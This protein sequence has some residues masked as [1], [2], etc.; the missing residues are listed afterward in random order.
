VGAGGGVR[1]YERRALFIALLLGPVVIVPAL[2]TLSFALP[3]LPLP[4]NR[5][6]GVYA[7]LANPG[8]LVLGWVT[9]GPHRITVRYTHQAFCQIPARPLVRPGRL[10]GSGV[11][12]ITVPCPPGMDYTIGV[13]LERPSLPLY[14]RLASTVRTVAHAYYDGSATVTLQMD[15]DA[16][17]RRADRVRVL[18][19]GA[20][21]R[22]GMTLY[23]PGTNAALRALTRTAVWPL[24]AGA[25]ASP[26][27]GF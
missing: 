7:G 23:A 11:S 4:Q 13:S 8:T 2:L 17:D 5:L 25:V 6:Q 20:S 10:V 26:T 22:G 1:W 21:T 9:G 19:A 12:V 15:L 27:P 3:M 14:A 16:L 24:P 18:M